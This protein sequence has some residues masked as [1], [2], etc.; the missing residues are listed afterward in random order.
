[1]I[2]ITVVISDQ[3]DSAVG[4]GVHRVPHTLSSASDNEKK[5]EAVVLNSIN[6]ALE[7]ESAHWAGTQIVQWDRKEGS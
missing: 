2:L 5:L 1:M 4:V 3:K 6:R 7:N